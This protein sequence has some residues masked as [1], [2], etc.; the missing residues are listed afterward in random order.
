[1]PLYLSELG[2]AP[3]HLPDVQRLLEDIGDVVRR[4][5]TAEVVEFQVTSNRSYLY[6]IVEAVDATE[7]ADALKSVVPVDTVVRGPDPVRLV[8]AE[9]AEVKAA[10]SAAG[11]LVEWDLPAE[12]GMDEYLARK[13]EKAPRYADVP[14]VTFL[15]TY[16]REDMDKCLCLYDAP[17]EDLVRK[18]REAVDS[19]VDRLHALREQS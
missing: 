17:D 19:P 15:R 11:Y 13:K 18:A 8:G 2:L 4:S 5:G 6:V 12:L 1:M 9:L 16:V 10:R 14:E 7:V 3:L